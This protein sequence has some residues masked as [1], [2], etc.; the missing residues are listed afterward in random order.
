M[1]ETTTGRSIRIGALLAAA[2]AA[3]LSWLLYAAT[4]G[5]PLL[6]HDPVRPAIEA[7]AV[8]ATGLAFV[9]GGGPLLI[10]VAPG[11]HRATGLQRTLVYVSLT[12][13]AAYVALSHYGFDL[14]TALATSA[15]ISA[16]V[17]FAMQPTLGSMISGIAL[18]IDHTLRVGDGILHGG[19]VIRVE[20]LNWRNVIGRKADGCMVVLPN[21]KLAD[22]ELE[23][24]PCG[25]PRRMEAFL[26]V[27]SVLP[28]QRVGEL[29]AELIG[30]IAE[31]DPTRPIVVA[32]AEYEADASTTRY[33]VRYWLRDYWDSTAA[34]DK[35]P[36]RLWYGFQR[37]RIDVT[38]SQADAAG[39]TNGLG[40]PEHGAVA[41]LISASLPGLTADAAQALAKDGEVLLFAPGERIT[42]PRRHEGWSFLLLR[43]EAIGVPEF[44]ALDGP[45]DNQPQPAVHQL[46]PSNAVRYVARE[47]T[48]HIGPYAEYA[49]QHAACRTTSLDELCGRVA[50]EIVDEAA[51]ARFL[52]KVRP[53]QPTPLPLGLLFGA[54]RDTAELLVPVRRLRARTEV[55]I[56][57]IP[58]DLVPEAAKLRPAAA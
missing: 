20:S 26:K 4:V 55:T 47:L 30:D 36:S 16:A 44:D 49:V 32:P 7:A 25:Q 48:H 50:A 58:P 51:R 14:R 1:S 8:V 9:L 5:D 40:W 41:G 39:R 46:N 19:E 23:I 17:G 3:I 33:R 52:D 27:P 37:A 6:G 45:A 57:A 42:L 22:A 24:L 18:N 29:T 34:E 31:V 12:M 15:I 2:T 54:E 10:A 35:I 21:A 43:G 13:V 28:P 11:G 38:P 53:E 56:L